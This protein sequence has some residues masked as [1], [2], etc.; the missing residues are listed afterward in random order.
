MSIA[1]VFEKICETDGG[2]VRMADRLLGGDHVRDFEN[3][4]VTSLLLDYLTLE[5][6]AINNG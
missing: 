3:M 5:F 6:L 4:T 2:V 1:A